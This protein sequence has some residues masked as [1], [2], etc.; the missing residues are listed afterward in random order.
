MS[1]RRIYESTMTSLKTEYQKSVPKYFFYIYLFIL[2]MRLHIFFLDFWVFNHSKRKSL[3]SIFLKIF[4]LVEVP[5][6]K[7]FLYRRNRLQYKTHCY[8]FNCT[9][10]VDR[11]FHASLAIVFLCWLTVVLCREKRNKYYRT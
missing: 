3:L 4:F 1:C 2:H 8:P 10:I 6:N 7:I 5:W 9:I 11:I